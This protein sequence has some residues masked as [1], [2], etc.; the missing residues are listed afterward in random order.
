MSTDITNPDVSTTADRAAA[1]LDYQRPDSQQTLAEGLAEL[2]TSFDGFIDEDALDGQ[3]RELFHSHDIAH[4]IFGCDTSLLQEAMVD[5]WTLFGSTVG[6]RA[7]IAYLGTE[8]AR[9]V[10]LDAGVARTLWT[11][12]RGLPRL[13]SVA[14]RARAMKKRWPWSEHAEYMNRPLSE[15]RTEFGI[16]VLPASA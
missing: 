15:I 9:R 10:I 4:V 1:P 2:R 14:R 7:Y 11:V 16:R 13:V 12:L 6:A 5:T 8:E 3:A